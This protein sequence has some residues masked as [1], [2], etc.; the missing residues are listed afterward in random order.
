MRDVDFDSEDLNGDFNKTIIVVNLR[1]E[2][3]SSRRIPSSGHTSSQPL[4]PPGSLKRHYEFSRSGNLTHIPSTAQPS[5]YPYAVNHYH[6]PSY[7]PPPQYSPEGL[8]PVASGA[9]T[10]PAPHVSFP[11]NTTSLHRQYS[12]PAPTLV[13]S[14]HTLKQSQSKPSSAPRPKDDFNHTHSQT[15]A[16]IKHVLNVPIAPQHSK[17]LSLIWEKK[18]RVLRLYGPLHDGH[19]QEK[20]EPNSEIVE[21]FYKSLGAFIEVL[22]YSGRSRNP[23]RDLKKQ[24]E[25]KL[26]YLN[27]RNF[28]K[29]QKFPCDRYR[30]ILE[31][32]CALVKEVW[33]L[34]DDLSHRQPPIDVRKNRLVDDDCAS[35]FSFRTDAY[36]LLSD[37]EFKDRFPVELNGACASRYKPLPSIFEP[38]V[39]DYASRCISVI[40]Q[41]LSI[42]AETTPVPK[43]VQGRKMGKQSGCTPTLYEYRP[44]S[45]PVKKSPVVNTD[46]QITL[47]DT[48][49]QDT[50]DVKYSADGKPKAMSVTAILDQMVMNQGKRD[51]VG[52]TQIGRDE[53]IGEFEYVV[54]T[55]F[56]YWMKPEDFAID[57]IN[58]YHKASDDNRKLDVLQVVDLWVQSFWTQD[59]MPAL[60]WIQQFI[61]KISKSEYLE[62][63]HNRIVKKTVKK[64]EELTFD[65]VPSKDHHYEKEHISHY[66]FLDN[67]RN[68]SLKEE[69]FCEIHL[70]NFA[71]A[72]GCQEF[73]EQLTLLESELFLKL[74]PREFIGFYISLQNKPEAK[75]KTK[76]KTENKHETIKDKLAEQCK[77]GNSLKLYTTHS[78]LFQENPRKRAEFLVFWTNVC[79]ICL[80]KRNFSS[81][82]SIYNGICSCNLENLNLTIRVCIN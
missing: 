53:E 30:I 59:D 52:K 63:P 62:F 34:I 17:R 49:H 41:P 8:T 81:A 68:L 19:A 12:E 4:N 44:L 60:L 46:S 28:Y 33:D 67:G 45:V 20:L 76:E 61:E 39:V 58:A 51:N 48:K 18:E 3:A 13:H 47:V 27:P 82:F 36:D 64:L 29:A 35:T 38:R 23:V 79:M 72:R 1:S 74:D 24:L 16:R 75:E 40:K 56:R 7:S 37:T 78:I 6:V 43:H 31:N 69:R 55:C 5:Y 32:T 73:A 57:L 25:D 66:S 11:A 54:L 71:S 65:E 50:D 77:F 22:P 2:A 26:P 80:E 42:R 70:T 9:S 14:R 10:L 21:E 15:G